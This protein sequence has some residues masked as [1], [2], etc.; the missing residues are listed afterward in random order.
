M[1]KI[2]CQFNM[3]QIQLLYYLLEKEAKSTER[4]L[5]ESINDK[6]SSLSSYEDLLDKKRVIQTLTDTIKK[7]YGG[8]H[9]K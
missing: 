9:A 4:F 1:E 5:S 3:E 8:V 2:N 7:T 6:K